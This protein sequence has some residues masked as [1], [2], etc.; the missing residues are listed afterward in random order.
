MKIWI[1]L[2]MFLATAAAT[3]QVTT[4]DASKK[5]LKYYSQSDEY[6]SKN[7]F[8]GAMEVL[9]KAIQTEP[10]FIDAYMRLAELMY[11]TRDIQGAETNFK[12][13]VDKYPDFIAKPY[14]ILGKLELDRGNFDQSI[15]YFN[16]Y[17]TTPGNTPNTVQE[18][19]VMLQSAKFAKERKQQ[20]IDFKP[21][22]L[23]AAINTEHHEYQPYTTADEAMLVFT[24]RI[25]PEEDFFTAAKGPDGKWPQAQPL[26]PPVSSPS[27]R[28]GS[29]TISPDGKT[30]FFA[31]DYQLNRRSNWDIFYSEWDGEN[32][33]KPKNLGDK[34]NSAN[35]ESQPSISADG[36]SLYFVS[37]RGGG[38]GGMDIWV[39]HLQDDCTWSDPVNLG[40]KIN[41]AKDEQVPFIHPDGHTLYFG[42]EGLTGMGGSD[43]FLVRKNESGEWGEPENLGFPI[44]STGNEG[45]IFVT[46]NGEKAYYASDRPGGEGLLDLY[47]FNMWQGIKPQPVTYVKAD[48]FDFVTGKKIEADFELTNLKTGKVIVTSKCHD[49]LKSNFLIV[50]PAGEEYAL[51]VYKPGYLFHSEHFSLK[52]KK[53]YKPE[54]LEIRLKPFEVGNTVVLNNVFF[55]TDSYQLRN[56]S[57]TELDRLVQMLKDN[58]SVKIEVGGYTDNVGTPAHNQTLS[59]N[60]AKAVYDYLLTNG[61]GKERLSYKGYGE[62]QPIASNETE[63]GRAKNRRT[64]FKV[65]SK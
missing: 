10:E 13:I 24:R 8:Q 65:V 59:T 29:I 12:T 42:S 26:G 46:T 44:N 31:A 40:P 14:Y 30:L 16:K 64:E 56:E 6:L 52:E 5:A 15:I 11:M 53:D 63:E 39:T 38:F 23:S 22:N 61:I 37:K 62:K 18:V 27:Y 33:G 28:E 54:Q 34:V 49:Y 32:W 50:L 47:E 45:S 20:N 9:Q 25:G 60:R 41:T 35:Y 36:R 21:V 17:L 58:A 2:L 55:E 4:K 51:N 7:D 3:A 43:V 19:K 57:K 1:S 48:I